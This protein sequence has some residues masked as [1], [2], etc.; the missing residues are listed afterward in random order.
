MGHLECWYLGKGYS[1]SLI[2][3][4]MEQFEWIRNIFCLDKKKVMG[5]V[6]LKSLCHGLT[7]GLGKVKNV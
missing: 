7:H 1:R 3:L 4:A 2:S 5:E 6:L